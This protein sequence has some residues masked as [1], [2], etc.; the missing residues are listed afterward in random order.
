MAGPPKIVFKA[1]FLVYHI[2]M[3]QL[4]IYVVRNKE[5]KYFRAKGFS[6]SGASW[7]EGLGTAR[8]YPRIGPARACVTYFATQYPKY[9]IPV[10]VVLTATE[11]KILDESARVKKSRD[12]KA[13][14]EA[15]HHLRRKTESLK[16]A[17]EA[18]RRA[19]SQLEKLK[20]E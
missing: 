7:V 6:G 14:I 20:E 2:R 15:A 18:F 13:R 10:I 5:G 16:E 11:T 3:E 19:K 9:G 17:E 4:E 8:L 12:N 1:G